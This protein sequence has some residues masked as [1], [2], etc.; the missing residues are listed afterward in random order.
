MYTHRTEVHSISVRWYT[1]RA[2]KRF[3]TIGISGGDEITLLFTGVT[4]LHIRGGFRGEYT[5]YGLKNKWVYAVYLRIPWTIYVHT[6]APPCGPIVEK[7][8]L[9][10][11][12]GSQNMC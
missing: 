12:L 10:C 8:T 2:G 4:L 7:C 9:K 11:P 6:V 3:H 1:T 5:Q